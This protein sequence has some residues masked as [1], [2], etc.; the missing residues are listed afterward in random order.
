[1]KEIIFNI[2]GR[3]PSKKNCKH[4]ITTK[5]GYSMPISSGKFKSWERQAIDTLGL[6]RIV[7]KVNQPIV[8]C[9]IRIEMTFPDLR[10]KD[11]G[12]MAEGIL[13]AMVDVGILQDD[14]WRV[15]N[16]LDLVAIGADKDKAGAKIIITTP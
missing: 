8:Q 15:V 3:V 4:I 5:A 10:R 16:R 1:M 2:N 11:L 12:N 13:D 7:N 9:S 6:Q 14:N